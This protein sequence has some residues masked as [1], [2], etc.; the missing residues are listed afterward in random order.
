M[1][2]NLLIALVLVIYQAISA[3]TSYSQTQKDLGR[4]YETAK[5]WVNI[6]EYEKAKRALERIID[7]QKSTPEQIFYSKL[8][9]AQIYGEGREL[10]KSL[11]LYNSVSNDS[12]NDM[13]AE[14]VCRYLDLL[15]RN[16]LISRAIEVTKRYHSN[17][18]LNDRFVNTE[19][20]LTTYYQYYQNQKSDKFITVNSVRT[21]TDFDNTYA[22]GII[23]YG[24]DYLL[25]TNRYNYSEAQSFY[26]NA[27]MVLLTSKRGSLGHSQETFAQL[28]GFVQQGPATFFNNNKSVIFT[29]NEYNKYNTGNR[30]YGSVNRLQLY[31]STLKANGKW[32]KP[33]NIST[34]F[35]R[36]ASNYSFLSPCIDQ[37]GKVLY[38]AS[39]MK[40][41]FGGT[42]IYYCKYDEKRKKWGT[43]VNMGEQVN[44]NGDEIFPCIKNDTL[45]FSSNGLVGFGDQDIFLKKISAP[46]D[47]AIHLP[48]PVNTQFKDTSPMFDSKSNTLFFAS[49]R[50]SQ[51]QK[52][53]Y[54]L[55]QVYSLVSSL[56]ELIL[57]GGKQTTD[58]DKSAKKDTTG[59][60]QIQELVTNKTKPNL[61]DTMDI[62]HF[63]LNKYFIRTDQNQRL[64]S[65]YAGFKSD[66]SKYIIAIDG[67]TDI[68]GT[69]KHNLTLSEMRAKSV[70]E[71]LIAKGV[72]KNAFEIQWFGFTRP[73]ATCNREMD[74]EKKCQEINA[75]NRRCEVYIKRIK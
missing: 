60:S 41:G 62:I 4:G 72:P 69:E 71:Y 12:D 64:D 73:I 61:R 13:P 11:D 26:T 3:T 49:D 32:S 19:T 16:G 2:R 74:T 67:H 23:P 21:P 1:K 46:N 36:K 54:I 10:G 56:S 20:A 30:P 9:L 28:G 42:D 70:M 68:T 63:D 44:T 22:Y 15:R 50:N 39:D 25:L 27:K 43:P 8:L 65:I 34:T 18:S 58:E 51:N 53:G 48:Y 7:D 40:G 45:L 17:L 31:L 59:L 24:S 35:I 37:D 47:P 66:P 38:F 33:V 57:K 75:L 55:E 14:H 29:A 52:A 6:Q 5:R